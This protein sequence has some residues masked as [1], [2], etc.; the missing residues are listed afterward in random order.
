LFIGGGIMHICSECEKKLGM[1]EGY[2]H[3]VEGST[4]LVCKNC[5]DKI[6]VSE[7]KYSNFLLEHINK[8]NIGVIYFILIKV[9]PTFEIKTYNKL[10]N[11][12][13]II[14]VYPLMGSYDFIVKIKAENSDELGKY[15]VNNIR[16]I[17][18]ITNTKTL[19]GTF[20]L[21]GAEY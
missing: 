9:A 10:F 7:N 6:E 12:P 21:T 2:R 14:E 8:T 3:P 17:D 5:W 20:S 19:L 11:L 18:G 1:L 16:K 15:V 4:K 13:E